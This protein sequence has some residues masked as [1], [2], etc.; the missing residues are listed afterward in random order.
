[1]KFAC[2]ESQY[3]VSRVCGNIAAGSPAGLSAGLKSDAGSAAAGS[4]AESC[5]FADWPKADKS[6]AQR[7]AILNATVIFFSVL[8]GMFPG[9]TGKAWG[10]FVREAHTGRVKRR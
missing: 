6:P 4:G 9:A 2:P 3:R 5:R 1:M 7:R 10:P 8:A